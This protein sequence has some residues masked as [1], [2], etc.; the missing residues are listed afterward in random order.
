MS[1]ADAAHVGT[2]AFEAGV[3]VYGLAEREES[4]EDVFLELTEEEAR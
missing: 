4:L 3:P 1:G 2:I